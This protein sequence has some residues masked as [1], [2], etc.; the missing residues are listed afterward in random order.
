M[1]H[2]G[3]DFMVQGLLRSKL[4]SLR[5]KIRK[6]KGRGFSFPVG[7]G[8]QK[9]SDLRDLFN[10]QLSKLIENGEVWTRRIHCA[11]SISRYCS[12]VA[13]YRHRYFSK[14]CSATATRYF[15]AKNW[16]A[17]ATFSATATLLH[18]GSFLGYARL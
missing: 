17:T 15:L 5:C 10:Y 7:F 4:S 11:Q 2:I 9:D 14:M 1:L 6:L 16:P 3:F 8:F 18:K 13:R 12:K